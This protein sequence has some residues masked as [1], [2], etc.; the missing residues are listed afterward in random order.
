MYENQRMSDSK[1]E[2]EILFDNHDID[3]LRKEEVQMEYLNCIL[4]VEREKFYMVSIWDSEM[5]LS[6]LVI[7]LQ[8]SVI[9]NWNGIILS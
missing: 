1:L 4:V 3:V 5:A 7:I 6:G 8:W 9:K 2:N